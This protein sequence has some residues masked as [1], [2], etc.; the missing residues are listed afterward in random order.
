MSVSILIF[1][2]LKPTLTDFTL[3]NS[4]PG[5]STSFLM[6]AYLE[7]GLKSGQYTLIGAWAPKSK[8]LRYAILIGLV[9]GISPGRDHS[10]SSS[11][12]LA[13]EV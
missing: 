5:L 11:I 2:V 4:D 3:P 10:T 1:T 7:C 8:V 13:N 12:Y 9:Y 6:S